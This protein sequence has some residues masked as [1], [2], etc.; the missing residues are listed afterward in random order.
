MAD[1]NEEMRKKLLLTANSADVREQLKDD[2]TNPDLWYKMGTALSAEEGHEAGIDAYSQGLVYNPFNASLYF[3]RGRKNIGLRHYW[4]C[5]SDTTMAIRIQPELWSHWYYRAVAYNLNGNHVEATADFMQCYN[6]TEPEEHYP[7]VDWLFLCALDMD[8]K[9][10]AREVLDLIDVSVI[11]PTM[12][13]AYRRR[14]MLYKGVVSPDEFIDVEHIKKNCLPLPNRVELEIE[15]L[16]FGLYAYYTFM[17]NTEKANEVLLR[18]VKFKPS[19]AFGYI[20]G[21]DI[22]QK[23]GLI[24]KEV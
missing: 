17:G 15:T 8:D 12:D 21:I 3:G 13:Y 2:P 11:P 10:K 7:M 16:T 4:R 19:A 1:K 9:E 24:N 14:V 23:R 20:K 18:I 6:I 22:A 5:I